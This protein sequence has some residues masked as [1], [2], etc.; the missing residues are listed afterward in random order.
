MAYH[1]DFHN[2][3]VKRFF[4]YIIRVTV[5][6]SGHAVE[7]AT[8]ERSVMD[9]IPII[10]TRKLAK[11]YDGIKAL[12]CFDLI[13]ERGE[14][15]ALLG[16]N[17]AG[18]TTLINLILGIINPNAP[19]DGGESI[20]MGCSSASLTPSIKSGIGLISGEA[21]PAPWASSTDLAGFFASI[22]ADW[23]SAWFIRCIESWG[24]DGK[25]RLQSLSKGQRRL[26]EIALVT[27]I[28]PRLL[29]LDEPFDGLDTVNRMGINVLFRGMQRD[30]GTTI[31][32]TTHVLEEAGKLADRVVILRGGVKAVD[33]AIDAL[34]EPL[35]QVFKRHYQIA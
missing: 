30:S 1:D 12:S 25:R 5:V 31:L 8:A 17:G 34:Q 19:P 15:V 24:I 21:S 26:A 9:S 4:E 16:A 11:T 33:C 2:S 32:Y 27:A 22:Y 18:K 23:D 14:S 28:R 7:P 13:V 3:I 20:V 35:E 6:D 10:E 29:V